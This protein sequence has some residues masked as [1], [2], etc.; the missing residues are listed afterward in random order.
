MKRIKLQNQ[1]DDKTCT[2]ACIAMILHRPVNEVIEDFHDKFMAD[3]VRASAYLRSQRIRTRACL[4]E[5]R[6]LTWGFVYL[7]AVPSI[8]KEA[9][10]HSV[11]VDMRDEDN[12]KVFDPQEGRDGR[13]YYKWKDDPDPD[14]IALKG[15][16]IDAEVIL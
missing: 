2:S 5:D 14:G 13:K 4:S 15:F 10:L 6:D 12:P 9:G 8:N 7:L 16:T 1:I 3:E 11:V